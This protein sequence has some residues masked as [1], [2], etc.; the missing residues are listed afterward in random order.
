MTATVPE[1]TT[2]TVDAPVT[3][4]G[5]NTDHKAVLTPHAPDVD[6]D[7]ADMVAEGNPNAD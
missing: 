2:S 4:T 5:L 7:A 1:A 6:T 3:D